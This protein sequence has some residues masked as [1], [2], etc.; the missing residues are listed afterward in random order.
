MDKNERFQLIYKSLSD[1]ISKSI[2]ENRIRY[3]ACDSSESI[4]SI[5]ETTETAHW[6][7]QM[8]SQ[9]ESRDIVLYGAGRMSQYI[10]NY[11]AEDIC[12]IVDQD[13]NKQGQLLMGIPVISLQTAISKYNTPYFLI[14]V[15]YNVEEI[16]KELMRCG[17]ERNRIGCF[18]AHYFEMRQN[19]YFDLPYLLQKK[20]EVFV[21]C[22]AYHGETSEQ[23]IKWCGKKY[24]HIYC[25]E[26]DRNNLEQCCKNL[27]D[28]MPDEKYTVINK[29]T[30]SEERC[31]AFSD[32]SDEASH[33]TENGNEK[34]EVC[35]LD[36]EL[37]ERRKERVTFIK[38]DIEGAELESLK[39][40]GRIIREQKP[41][42]AICVYHKKEDIFDIP[43]YILSLNPKYKLYLR[44]YTLGEWDTVLYAIP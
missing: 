12:A 20:D 2:F 40:A 42:L 11:C 21:D 17:I 28:N 13:E 10:L 14:S 44:H 3:S 32:S 26:P 27:S 41:K 22:G 16:I 9:H 25:F 38:M 37:Y 43:E 19:Q 4:R 7:K 31:L 1:E 29:G 34:I 36:E 35:S 8:I 18:Y 23:F 15:K 5:I 6:L 39:G 30:W 24:K 33:I